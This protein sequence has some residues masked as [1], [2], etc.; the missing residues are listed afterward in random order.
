MTNAAETLACGQ[1]VDLQPALLAV[2]RKLRLLKMEHAAYQEAVKFLEAK[3]PALTRQ[4]EHCRVRCGQADPSRFGATDN[5]VL[6]RTGWP[7]REGKGTQG[8]IDYRH[9][10][11][12]CAN[13]YPA[14]LNFNAVGAKAS[15]TEWLK[16]AIRFVR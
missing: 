2:R 1:E 12:L 13:V 16:E 7:L 6:G 8:D 3:L 15:L 14:V 10:V 5:Q 9:G 4:G 11:S